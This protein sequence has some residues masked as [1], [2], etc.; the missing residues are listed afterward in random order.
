MTL[1]VFS[2]MP[3]NTIKNGE[4]SEKLD[5]FLTLNL[6]HF[7]TL[8]P[9]N[10]GPLFNFT[11]YIYGKKA[12]AGRTDNQQTS[13]QTGS[14]QTPQPKQQ[15]GRHAACRQANK[16]HANQTTPRPA[17]TPT[18]AEASKQE[19]SNKPPDRHTT[20]RTNRQTDRQERDRERR[21]RERE[22]TK[23]KTG[24]TNKKG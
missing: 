12:A 22:R 17:S 13:W 20:R 2:K 15:E 10:L 16:R 6:D 9:S 4:N 5:Q 14:K 18:S 11:L 21:E 8:K 24:K 23:K 3:K 19:A 1:F 7:L